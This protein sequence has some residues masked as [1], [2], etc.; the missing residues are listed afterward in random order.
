MCLYKA[1]RLRKKSLFGRMET[2]CVSV[3]GQ[4]HIQW[5]RP[6]KMSREGAQYLTQCK[7]KVSHTDLKSCHL[8]LGTA[9]FLWSKGCQSQT[10]F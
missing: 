4:G 2:K 3:M 10:S 1:P 8:C 7:E 9:A 6:K 5:N